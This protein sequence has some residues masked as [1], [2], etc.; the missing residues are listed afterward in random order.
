MS[1][2]LVIPELQENA[3]KSRNDTSTRL[4]QRP[5]MAELSL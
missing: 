3:N 4:T 5:F 2:F 1:P